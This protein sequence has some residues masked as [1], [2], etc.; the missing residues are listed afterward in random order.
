MGDYLPGMLG[1]DPLKMDG[2]GMRNAEI[3][4]GRVAMMAITIYAYQEAL[5]K[6]PIFPINLIRGPVEAVG[7]AVGDAVSAVVS[8]AVDTPSSG[9]LESL[10][11]AADQTEELAREQMAAVAEPLAAVADAVGDA[12]ADAAA[13]GAAVAGAAADAVG[14]AAA[15]GAAV[16]SG[17]VD[18]VGGM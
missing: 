13:A 16:G 17:V 15:A 1:F 4:N 3:T 6:A 11:A 5:I 7:G 14:D 18:A 8:A 9:A 2:P 12:V 10:L